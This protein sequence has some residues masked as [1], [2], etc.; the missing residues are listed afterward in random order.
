[1]RHATGRAPRPARLRCAG[2]PSAPPPTRL[3]AHHRR[4]GFLGQHLAGDARRPQGGSWSRRRRTRSTCATASGCSSRWPS[5]SRTRSSTSRTASATR[6]SIVEAARTSPRPRRPCGARLVHLST[7][8][9][10]RRAGRGRTPRPTPRRRSPTTGGGR[11]RPS[12]RSRRACPGRGARA[13]VAAV[14][15]RAPRPD[16]QVAVRDRRPM[17]WSSPT[18]S[19]A[20]RTPPTSPPRLSVAGRPPGR[21]RPAPRRRAGAAQP[22]RSRPGDRPRGWG[23][24]RRRCAPHHGAVGH[25]RP[26]RVVSTAPWPRRRSAS[27]AARLSATVLR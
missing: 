22:S 13:H 12:G 26:G 1:M 3:D 20:R 23:S 10:L 19:A 5:G 16:W 2:V 21:P 8:R 15:H 11:P 6:R 4:Q 9:G 7:D 27:T 18:S 17:T 24:T 14:R 25:D